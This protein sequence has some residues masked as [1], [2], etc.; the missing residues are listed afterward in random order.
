MALAAESLPKPLEQGSSDDE[1]QLARMTRCSR[2][3][4]L[5]VIEPQVDLPV[6]RCVQCGDCIDPVI[7]QNRQRR[8]PVGLS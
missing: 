4:G 2:C 3:G 5:M 8:L 7:L 1:K 6:R